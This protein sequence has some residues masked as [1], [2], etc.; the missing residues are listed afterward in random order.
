GK[1]RSHLMAKRNRLLYKLFKNNHLDSITYQLSLLEELPGKPFNLPE[2]APHLL[3]Y[4]FKKHKGERIKSTIDGNLQLAVNAIVDK[5]YRTLRQNQIH[6]AAILVMDVNTREVLSYVGNTAT[7]REHEKDVDMVQV[8]R[9]TGSVIKPWLYMAMLDA[10]ELL[11][12]M[13]VP[14]VPTRIAGYTPENFDLGY[15]GAVRA[16]RALARSLNIPSV[17]LL[18]TYGLQ[19]FRDQLDFFKLKGLDRSADHYGLTLILGGAESSLWD[20]CKTYASLASTVNHFNGTS[21]EY[22]KGEFVEPVVDMGHKIDFGDK[23]T[24]KT[25]FDA[26]SIYLTFEAMKE[27][28]RPEGDESWE[29]YDSSKE[30]AWKTG[31]SFGNKD[32]W[33]IGVTANHVVGVWVG[34]ADGEGRPNMMGL[35][36]AAPILFDV[37]D[38]LPTASWFPKPED[39]FSKIVVC[40]ESGYLASDICP[41]STIDIPDK[42]H[43]VSVCKYHRLVHLDKNRQFQVNSSCANV[44]D[45]VSEPWLV[46]PPLMGYYYQ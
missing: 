45:I 40:A 26:A 42:Q 36:S 5:H 32:A 41:K 25:I 23:S 20:L 21:S 24:Q 46:L 7:D 16:D 6:N 19:K 39:S 30:I 44:S 27:V 29:F 2:I 12:G 9:S 38:V 4:Q 17:R 1:N 11:P 10:G 8:D 34:N 13:L 31:T 28:N 43:Y 14:D 3:Q 33:A 37:F 22:Y 18:Q 15:S 35:N